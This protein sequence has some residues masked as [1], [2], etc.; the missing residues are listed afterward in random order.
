M[1]LTFWGLLLL[2]HAKSPLGGSGVWWWCCFSCENPEEKQAQLSVT[3][4]QH[5][6]CAHRLVQA[7]LASPSTD[8]VLAD[9]VTQTQEESD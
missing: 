2:L 6:A 1:T 3:G 8:E 9:S 4:S 5:P 7:Y